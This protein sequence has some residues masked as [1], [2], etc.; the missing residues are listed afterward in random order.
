[1]DQNLETLKSRKDKILKANFPKT[2]NPK[3][4]KFRNSKIPKGL[5]SRNAKIFGKPKPECVKIPK[6]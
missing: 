6:S 3:N 1:M 5:K 2:Q 4:L